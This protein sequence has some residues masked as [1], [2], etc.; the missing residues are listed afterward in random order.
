MPPLHGALD[1]LIDA[2]ET[3]LGGRLPDLGREDKQ[4]AVRLLDE[5]GAF[6]LRRAVEQVADA[7]GVSRITVYNYLNA[8]HRDVTPPSRARFDV[9]GLDA[10]DTLWHSEDSFRPRR[11]ALRRARRARSPRS[12]STSPPRCGRPSGPTCRSSGYGVKAFT[13]AM[14]QGGRSR[15]PRARC[16]RP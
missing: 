1:R 7:M 3:E 2:V 11:G 5:R 15:S 12:A 6:T 9:I 13:L 10:D 8:I 14:V 4:R 16:R